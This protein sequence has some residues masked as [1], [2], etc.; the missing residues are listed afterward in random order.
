M[1]TQHGDK[2]LNPRMCPSPSIWLPW[3]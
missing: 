1:N 3:L 2:G